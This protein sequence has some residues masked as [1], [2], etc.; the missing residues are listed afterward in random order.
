VN[1]EQ[2][3]VSRIVRRRPNPGSEEAFQAECQVIQ[4]FATQT[5][6]DN[7]D[8]SPERAVWHERIRPV[9][10]RGADYHPMNELEVWFPSKPT[11]SSGAPP[12]WKMTVVSWLGIFP[13]AAACWQDSAQC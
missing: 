11:T 8:N 6:L 1:S 5:D 10:E 12:R 2:G 7:W 3:A 9:A 4:C 13:T